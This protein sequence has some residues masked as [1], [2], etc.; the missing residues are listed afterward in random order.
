[1]FPG[2]YLLE[3]TNKVDLFQKISSSH[4][5]HAMFDPIDAPEAKV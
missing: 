3:S 2:V 1:M 5:G 4:A